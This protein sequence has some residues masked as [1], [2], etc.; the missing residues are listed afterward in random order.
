VGLSLLFN[1]AGLSIDYGIPL[2]DGPTEP[3]FLL[4]VALYLAAACGMVLLLKRS[5]AAAVGLALW[6]AALLPTQ[7]VVPK[8]DALS[9]R[10]LS[11]AL[12]GLL[13]VATPLLVAGLGRLVTS[14][15]SETVKPG[16][17]NVP[18]NVRTVAA[19]CALA[20]ALFMASATT[21]RASLFQ[22]ELK[23]WRDAALKS[24]TN[25]RPYL[26][27]TILLLREGE[28]SEAVQ[29]LAGARR[30]DPFSSRIAGLSRYI[31][32]KEVS[33]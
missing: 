19:C 21:N 18:G 1:P 25:S 28:H 5:R 27:Y 26:Q 31:N 15:C 30:I 14:S 17:Q 11:L 2:P 23:L 16:F 13:L 4:G 20:A 9:N 10:P 7:S 22:S 29:V 12:A 33:P 3:L 8:L 6:L 24:R 32:P